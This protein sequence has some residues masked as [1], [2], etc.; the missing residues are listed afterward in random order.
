MLGLFMW[1]M[2]TPYGFLAAPKGHGLDGARCRPSS[3]GGD[4][5]YRASCQGK[6]G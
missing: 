1:V 4:H 2:P 6:S 5:G 3:L